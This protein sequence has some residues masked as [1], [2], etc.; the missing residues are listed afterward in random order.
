MKDAERCKIFNRESL[1]YYNT[2]NEEIVYMSTHNDNSMFTVLLAGRTLPNPEYGIYHLKTVVHELD[3][4]QFEYVTNGKGY[5]EIGGKTYTIQKGDFFFLNKLQ[6]HI[7]YTDKNQLLEKIFVT[8]KGTLIDTLVELYGLKYSHII[9]KLDVYD[10]LSEILNILSSVYENNKDECLDKVSRIILKIIQLYHRDI[11]GSTQ[12]SPVCYAENIKTYI[13]HNINRRFTLND[14][15]ESFF[16]SK[17]QIIR[18]FKAKYGLTP[19]Q[20]AIIKRLETAM[21]LLE[22]SKLTVKDIAASLAFSDSK[23]FSKTFHSVTGLSPMQYRQQTFL[24]KKNQMK[25]LL[26]KI[27]RL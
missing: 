20:Y 15:S 23:H 16:M 26:N 18:L 1:M 8:V 3:R 25:E 24:S 13:E 22:N 27:D 12:N 14:L 21:Y 9:H 7:Y 6:P 17:T 19:M 11:N 4:Y 10:N 5:V 2:K